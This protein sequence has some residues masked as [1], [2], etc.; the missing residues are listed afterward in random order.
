MNLKTVKSLLLLALFCSA[1]FAVTIISTDP[2]GG[3]PVEGGGHPCSGDPVEGEYAL[4]GGDPVEGGG[5]PQG[6]NHTG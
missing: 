3:D 2:C 1:I 6:G 4:C 5:H